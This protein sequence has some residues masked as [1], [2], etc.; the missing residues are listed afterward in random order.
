MV[1]LELLVILCCAIAY[2]K[3]KYGLFILCLISLLSDFFYFIEIPNHH[4]LRF[5]INM[6]V[7]FLI[8]VETI[9]N[10]RFLSIKD[11]KIGKAIL[12]VTVYYLLHAVVTVSIGIETMGNAF[13]VFGAEAYLMSYFLFRRISFEKIDGIK[14]ILFT[15][16]IIGAIAYYLQFAGVNLIAGESSEDMATGASRYPNFPQLSYI[17]ILYLLFRKGAVPNR[18]FWLAFLVPLVILPMTR[19]FMVAFSLAICIVL[20]LNKDFKKLARYA[21]PAAILL[22][23]FGSLISARFEGRSGTGGFVNEVTNALSLRSSSDFSWANSDTFVFRI[24]IALERIEYISSHPSVILTGVGSIY[25]S[26]ETVNRF[27]FSIGSGGVD[28]NDRYYSRQ[29]DTT[30]ISF[31]THFLRFGVA[32]LVFIFTFLVCA[33][34]RFYKYRNVNIYSMIALVLLIENIIQCLS[35]APFYDFGIQRMFPLLLVTGMI[36]KFSHTPPTSS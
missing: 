11:D 26:G 10:K 2:T 12:L 32:Y 4:A 29:L 27:N 7:L 17:T 21:L 28:S 35:S 8:V 9:R 25:E 5:Y 13:K 36:E 31:I 34:K 18:G 15:I 20:F 16:T 23:I 14:H 24:A 3:R 6:M 22:V 19:G 33:Y 30:D 1:I